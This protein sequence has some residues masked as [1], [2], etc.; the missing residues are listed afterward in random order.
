MK[1]RK[2]GAFTAGIVLSLAAVTM[3]FTRLVPDVL[4][5]TLLA[6]GFLLFT[7][8]GVSYLKN[9][10]KEAKQATEAAKETDLPENEG[11]KELSEL[12]ALRKAGIIDEQEYNYA[13]RRVKRKSK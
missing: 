13:V 3:Y 10:E 12:D 6:I 9:L 7:K 1:K 5:L 2:A 4:V 8:G 11:E